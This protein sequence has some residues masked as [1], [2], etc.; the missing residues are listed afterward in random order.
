MFRKAIFVTLFVLGALLGIVCT[1]HAD[2][3]VGHVN[4][5]NEAHKTTVT[6]KSIGFSVYD[7]ED[8][9]PTGVFQLLG[10][11]GTGFPHI[12]WLGDGTAKVHFSYVAP[13]TG[14]CMAVANVD[15]YPSPHQTSDD[16]R[17]YGVFSVEKG[18]VHEPTGPFVI[19]DDVDGTQHRLILY[20]VCIPE[21]EHPKTSAE[22]LNVAV[23]SQRYLLTVNPQS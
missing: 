11:K 14:A 9:L 20:L 3:V 15:S 12:T 23:F 7:G 10:P 19:K 13:V 4:S 6:K 5:M 2:T 18:D 21:G 17:T 22:F 16:I 1:A 8:T